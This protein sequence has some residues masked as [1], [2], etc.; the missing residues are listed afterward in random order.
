VDTRSGGLVF[1]N[2]GSNS[3]NFAAAGALA[4][5]SQ[6]E[7]QLR[8]NASSNVEDGPLSLLY[9]P[10]DT[11]NVVMG[12]ISGL[13]GIYNRS[14]DFTIRRTGTATFRLS[15]PGQTPETGM[16]LLTSDAT[17]IANDNI[18]SYEADGSDFVIQLDW[19][20]WNE[21]PNLL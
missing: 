4:D 13:G 11:A 17:S 8:D 2:G 20:N 18:I 9:L 3:N 5:G 7:I 6:F 14:G 12:R 21:V 1:A 16:L 19:T 15:I 10:Y